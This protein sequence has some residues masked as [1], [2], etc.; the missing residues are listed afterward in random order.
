M[1]EEWTTI[2]LPKPVLPPAGEKAVWRFKATHHPTE[3]EV[4]GFIEIRRPTAVRVDKLDTSYNLA[5][6]EAWRECEAEAA[7]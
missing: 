1:P 7:V 5:N 6:F 2:E 3:T 4:V